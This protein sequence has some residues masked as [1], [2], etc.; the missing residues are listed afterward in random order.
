MINRKKK[1]NFNEIKIFQKIL[2][3]IGY[4]GVNQKKLNKTFQRRF[5]PDL[6]NGFID[7]ECFV[8]AK[9]LIKLGI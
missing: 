1:L 6:I 9:N 7:Q 8:I 5:R 2:K 3:K 4:R